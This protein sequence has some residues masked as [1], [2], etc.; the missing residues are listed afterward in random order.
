[1]L[2]TH[3]ISHSL[4]HN[5]YPWLA[6]F[7]THSL[8]VSLTHS[9]RSSLTVHITHSSMSHH[10]SLTPY[11]CHSSFSMMCTLHLYRCHLLCSSHSRRKLKLWSLRRCSTSRIHHPYC[12]AVSKFIRVRM[13][14]NVNWM[15]VIRV[16]MNVN[17]TGDNVGYRLRHN[18]WLIRD[19]SF[20]QASNRDA[21]KVPIVFK[22]HPFSTVSGSACS[23]A[24][25][26]CVED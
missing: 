20:K 11:V 12:A 10:T 5:V 7:I 13:A 22:Q 6:E 3:C 21:I 25:K 14:L 15:N 8:I 24:L 18:L 2:L 23:I 26:R 9:L 1:M 4:T 16:N 17:A 19:S